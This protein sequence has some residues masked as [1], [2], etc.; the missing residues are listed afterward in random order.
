VITAPPIIIRSSGFNVILRDI[1]YLQLL[2]VCS[3]CRLTG[4]FDRF[5]AGPD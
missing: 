4:L 3:S 2:V 5:G 1:R